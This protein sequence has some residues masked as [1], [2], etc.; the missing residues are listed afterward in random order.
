VRERAWCPSHREAV[1]SSSP[2][3][4]ALPG[5]LSLLPGSTPTWP[6]SIPR[7]AT[8]ILCRV[9]GPGNAQLREEAALRSPRSD[10][11]VV[12]GAWRVSPQLSAR[13][14]V[15]R[16]GGGAVRGRA[17]GA[18]AAAGWWWWWCCGGRQRRRG[19]PLRR[20]AGAACRED[21]PTLLDPTALP[22]LEA[23]GGRE[24]GLNISSIKC[25]LGQHIVYRYCRGYLVLK[26]PLQER[27]ED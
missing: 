23:S 13:R 1:E 20:C 27:L 9:S 5:T 16:G 25:R 8:T 12:R 7:L 24:W 14:C 4:G 3:F 2:L 21:L 10:C 26:T 22:P 6:C 19:Q 18:A 11:C 15:R 17:H